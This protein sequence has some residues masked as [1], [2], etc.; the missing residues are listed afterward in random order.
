[1]ARADQAGEEQALR[2]LLPGQKQK[3]KSERGFAA[4]ADLSVNADTEDWGDAEAGGG[5]GMPCLHD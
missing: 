3:K 1:M 4:L 2:A 5:A